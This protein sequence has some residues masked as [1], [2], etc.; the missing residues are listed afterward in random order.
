MLTEQVTAFQAAI[1]RT[2]A[3]A[4]QL[5]EVARTSN[6]ADMGDFDRVIDAL[7]AAVNELQGTA[8]GAP[9][10]RKVL[11]AAE[12]LQC[13]RSPFD[14]IIAAAVEARASESPAE[15]RVQPVVDVLTEREKDVLRLLPTSLS[16]NEM[17]AALFVGHNTIKTHLRN[18]YMKLYV[19]SR[20]EA[21]ERA[22]ELGLL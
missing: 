5:R 22:V 10:P 7:E 2:E 21:I 6:Q 17:A 18:I 4:M 20:S 3:A 16:C 14:R 9:P 11:P 8:C 12:A 15:A 1:W 13:L 19:R